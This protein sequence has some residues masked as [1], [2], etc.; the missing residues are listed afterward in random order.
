MAT[1]DEIRRWWSDNPM[2]YDWRG[3]IPYEPGSAE[4]LAEVE[5]RFLAEAWFA[6]PAGA[7]PFSGLIPFE[8]LRGK[9]VLEIGAGTGVHTKLLAEAGARVSAVDLTP[10][11]VELTGRRLELAGLSADV[12][13]ADAES[14]PYEDASF[15]FVWSWGV[16]HHSAETNRVIAE[17]A[18]V[19]RPGGRLAF[20]V[21]HR[22][23]ITFWLN[24]VAYRGVLR[25]GLLRESPDQLANRWSDGVLARHYTRRTLTD[26][27]RPWFAD[28][29]TQVMGQIGEAIPL[30][31]RLRQPLARVVPR[32]AQ[33]TV[34][35]HYGWF[36]FAT[37]RR[38]A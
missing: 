33:E 32:R 19:L 11:A 18:R 36:L 24:Y 22:T 6:Q 35:R 34:V 37:A 38:K 9:D 3:E 12:R 13:E 30:P 21:Y 28:I 25:G 20:M 15:D 23:S 26:A 10:T 1:Q 16:I 2:T 7:P 17:I 29:D 8:E 14:L 27:L 4:H 31:S 5:R